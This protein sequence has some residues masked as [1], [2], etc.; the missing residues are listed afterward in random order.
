MPAATLSLLFTTIFLLKQIMLNL[1]LFGPPGAGK[2]TQSA[3]IIQNYGLMHLSTGDMLRAEKASGSELG[4]RVTAIMDSG[5]LVSDAIVIELIRKRLENNPDAPGFIFDGF[6][7][8]VAQALALDNMLNEKDLGISKMLAL[9][10]DEDELT[11]RLLERGKVSGRADDQNKEVIKN[12]VVEYYKKTA[13][14]ASYYQ[15]QNK[16]VDIVGI[17]SID[18]IFQKLVDAIAHI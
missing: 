15:E 1:V 5:K 14:V 4:Q 3:I 2:G 17:G 13:P 8:T 11:R 10:V 7:R 12:R 16:Y 6:P 18:D 9:V